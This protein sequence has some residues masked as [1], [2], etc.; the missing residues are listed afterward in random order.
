[1]KT[2]FALASGR[3][4]THFLYEVIHRNAANCVARHEPYI[5]NP[6]MFGK[7]IYHHARGETEPIRRLLEKK[8][9]FIERF[10][11]QT[12]V[13]TSHAFLKSY[14]DLAPEYFPEMKLV[15]LVRNPLK[16]AQ[17]L[18]NREELIRRL[19]LPFV[20][21]R[22]ADGQRYFRW[23]LTGLEPIYQQFDVAKLSPFQRLL[24]EWIEIENRAM[25]FLDR[26][27]KH[28]DC[29]TLHTPVDM[30]DPDRLREMFDQLG[31]PLRN[32][33]L[34]LTGRKNQT[35]GVP[36]VITDAEEQQFEEVVKQLPKQ[37]AGIFAREP[38]SKWDWS[39][40]F[41]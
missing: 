16:A 36:T 8:R 21:Y 18:A 27:E 12:Y 6:S 15:H 24:V 33:S 4:G 14:F 35:P 28:A 32:N 41:G 10:A 1:L 34:E 5:F 30:N 2:I 13:E 3:S 7:P 11:P 38:Y 22:G 23:A 25:Q 40:R 19:H 39:Q 31:I 17:S 26:W 20:F 9:R 29:V 37:Y